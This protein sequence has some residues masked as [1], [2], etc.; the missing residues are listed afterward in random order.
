MRK[1]TSYVCRVVSLTGFSAAILTLASCS[2]KGDQAAQMAA[3]QN[4]APE[5]AVVTVAPGS[6]DLSNAYAATIKGKVDV[7][8]R[9][10]VSGF[11]TKVHVD[12]GQYVKKG[13]TL[14]TL[15]QVTYQAAVEQAQAQVASAQ[16][17]VNSAKLTADNKKLLYDKNIISD[18]EY[19]LA[20]NQL[21]T[22]Q[23]QLAT[24]Q[25]ALT[26]AR[27]NLSYTVVTAPVSGYVGSIPG[28]EGT[29]AS[30]SMVQ[31]LTSVSDNSEVYAYFS[32][33][34]KDIL[35]MTQGD[36]S[37]NAAV[38]QMPDV[39]LRLADG[40]IYPLTGKVATVSGVVDP[41]TGASSVR[42][43]FANPDGVLR[44]GSTGLILIPNHAENV[45]LIPQRATFEVQDRRFVYVLNDSNK[46]VST[47]ITVSPL[48]DGQNYV[49]TAGLEPGQR[50]VVEGV[51]TKVRPDMII[52]PVDA[53]EKAAA[54]AAQA[55]QAQQAQQK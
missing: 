50:V 31:P 16:T 33:T 20:L 54:Q 42:A 28:R 18:Y 15:D 44:S 30:P 19:Q 24:S 4:Q 7:D 26:S 10:L 36:H 22:A 47:P 34:E 27:K 43:R 29:L 21:A 12:E 17:A 46:T 3:M 8:V 9:P 51:G 6:S 45:I 25:A 14:F 5:L 52:K 38:S 2:G 23:S 39:Q 13:Q 1:M 11:V 40:T 37:L 35:A 53:A 55:Q 48:D 41:S 32:L 49:V